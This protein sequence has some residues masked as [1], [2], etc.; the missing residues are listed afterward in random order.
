LRFGTERFRREFDGF[1]R[2][3][4]TQFRNELESLAD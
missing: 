4:Y 2:R 3:Y 1:V